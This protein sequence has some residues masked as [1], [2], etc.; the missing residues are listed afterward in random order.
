MYRAQGRIQGFP[1][2]GVE[3]RDTKCGGGRGGGGCC[4]LKA[5]YESKSV[6]GGGGGRFRPDTKSGEGAV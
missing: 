3:T 4:P 6:G 1:K 2:G 5:R